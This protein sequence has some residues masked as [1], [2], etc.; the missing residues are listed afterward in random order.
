MHVHRPLGRRVS[1]PGHVK[2][3]LLMAWHEVIVGNHVDE[4]MTGVAGRRGSRLIALRRIEQAV[5]RGPLVIAVES[6]STAVTAKQG[7]IGQA[8]TSHDPLRKTFQQFRP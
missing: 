2:P 8:G 3:A 4:K 5:R 6:L 7:K 1:K